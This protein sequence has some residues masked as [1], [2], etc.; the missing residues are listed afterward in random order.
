MASV[1]QQ[2]RL[3]KRL[4]PRVAIQSRNR[5]VGSCKRLVQLPSFAGT[6]VYKEIWKKAVVSMKQLNKAK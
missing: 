1:L 5:N 3:L 2:K 6:T 4:C